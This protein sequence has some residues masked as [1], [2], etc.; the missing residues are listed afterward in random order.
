MTILVTCPCG[1]R[2][3]TSDT[4]RG[5]RIKCPACGEVLPVPDDSDS[6]KTG[7]RLAASPAK[8]AKF[9]DD[10][11]AAAEER[12]RKKKKKKARSGLELPEIEFF[13]LTFGKL[14]ILL[15]VLGVI[16][17]GIWLFVPSSNAQIAEVRRVDVY[18][19]LDV[20]EKGINRIPE[21]LKIM[22]RA[23][24]R[25]TQRELG[26]TVTDDEPDALYLGDNK[27]LISRD[28][29][30]G[31][32]LILRVALSPR[33]LTKRANIQN[34]TIMIQTS[35]V[36]L[37]GDG[38]DVQGLLIDTERA[39]PKVLQVS[40]YGATQ[41]SQFTPHDRPP[42]THPGKFSLDDLKKEILPPDDKGNK[43]L[44]YTGAA[45]FEGRSGMQVNYAYDGAAVEMTWDKDSKALISSKSLQFSASQ[46][47]F[48]S[49]ELTCVFPR[50]PG[51]YVTPIVMGAEVSKLKLP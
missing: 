2:M 37:K 38:G 28:S 41:D 4:A 27:L 42:W 30:Q 46:Y 31:D 17:G 33:F 6:K 12:P 51:R 39:L 43:L 15:A 21:A 22:G 34:G 45:R 13:G 49:L 10:D 16:A 24:R 5:K 26:V 29:S 48:G 50:P 35:D 1:K 47:T 7:P 32:S 8:P 14:L 36:V 9:V 18:A 11:D 23:V 3:Q 25:Q 19:A 20:G 44:S 40:F